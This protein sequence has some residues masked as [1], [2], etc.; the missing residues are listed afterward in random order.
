[1]GLRRHRIRHE[2]E[3]LGPERMTAKKPS[4]RH[5]TAGPQPEAIERLIGIFRTGRQVT[6]LEANER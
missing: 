1:M 2:I 5:P 6:A 4:Q 3:S